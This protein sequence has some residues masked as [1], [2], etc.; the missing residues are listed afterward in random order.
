M[1]NIKPATQAQRT[2]SG[3]NTKENTP[4][5]KQ[6]QKFSGGRVDRN[7]LVHAGDTGLNCDLGRLHM[8][9]RLSSRTVTTGLCSRARE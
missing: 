5:K 6:G 3:I 1:N 8:L 9:W 2:F 4:E 7:P